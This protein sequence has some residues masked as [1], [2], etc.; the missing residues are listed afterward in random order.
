[1]DLSDGL[2][3]D[4]PKLCAASGVAAHVDVARLPLSSAL[5]ALVPASEARELALAAGDDYE[6]LIAVPPRRL[7]DLAA[8]ARQLNLTLT[9]IGEL[10]PGNGV[11]W[12]FEGRPYATLAHGYDH[13]R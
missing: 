6:L 8:V 12:A 11:T 3:G 9:P 2:V 4:L 7:D 13:F 1:M 5:R 10:R